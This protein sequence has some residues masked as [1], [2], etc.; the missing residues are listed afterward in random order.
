[1]KKFDPGI[2]YEKTL[3]V[4]PDNVAPRFVPGTPE[5]FA[6]PALVALIELTAAD[7]VADYLEAGETTVGT[8]LRLKHTA[9]TPIGMT[10]RCQATLVEVDRRRLRFNVAAWDQEEKICEGQH[11]RFVVNSSSFM[12]ILSEKASK[13]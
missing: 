5:A 2:P 13:L 4:A 9:P 12:A 11:E 7:L 6:T 1:M 8:S 3:Q 10:V